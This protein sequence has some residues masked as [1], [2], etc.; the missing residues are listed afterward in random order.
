M[1]YDI[2][3]PLEPE[4]RNTEHTHCAKCFASWILSSSPSAGSQTVSGS[5]AAGGSV[6]SGSTAPATGSAFVNELSQLAQLHM[7]GHLDADEYRT[8]KRKLLG[9]SA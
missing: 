6:A 7:Q 4:D 9:M 3:L 1:A 5:G 8:A 2:S